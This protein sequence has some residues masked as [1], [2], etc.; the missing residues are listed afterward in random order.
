[1]G[2]IGNC[3]RMTA[4]L[5]LVMA[6]SN[7][8]APIPAT[9]G[10]TGMHT[11]ENGK[12]VGEL[13]DSE[14]GSRKKRHGQGTYTFSS[15]AKY[16]GEWRDDK[17]HGQG[18]ET[19]ASGNKYVGEWRD[20]KKHGQGTYTFPDGDKYVGEWRDDKRNGLGTEYSPQGAVLWNGIW[21]DGE[22]VAR[23]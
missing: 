1:M 19:F 4:L 23:R 20:D 18:T 3:V 21:H 17:R 16:V 14:G 7:R 11:H 12:Y 15:G 8:C 6:T 5:V 2:I 13:R 10:Y 9:P 22:L